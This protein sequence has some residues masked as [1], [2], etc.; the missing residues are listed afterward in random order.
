MVGKEE[1]DVE[2]YICVAAETFSYLM[3]AVGFFVW[4]VVAEMKGKLIQRK[5]YHGIKSESAQGKVLGESFHFD[6]SLGGALM[7]HFA[8]FSFYAKPQ[9][10]FYSIFEAFQA[11]VLL[12]R[13]AKPVLVK[14]FSIKW[15]KVPVE[16]AMKVIF[17]VRNL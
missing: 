5:M 3:A 4:V 12:L 10:K 2:N 17:P 13:F 9:E 14:R 16:G 7:H 6:V 1:N 15:E 8:S 11:K